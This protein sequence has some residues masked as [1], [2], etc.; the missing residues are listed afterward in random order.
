MRL[1]AD[2]TSY[3]KQSSTAT[4]ETIA[5]ETSEDS[6]AL[7]TDL[8]LGYSGVGNGHGCTLLE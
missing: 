6:R 3:R 7:A 1:S 4:T 5:E 8:E 2:N